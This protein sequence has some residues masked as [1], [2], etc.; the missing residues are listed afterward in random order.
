MT[1]IAPAVPHSAIVSPPP[2]ALSRPR[3]GGAHGFSAALDVLTA[4]EGNARSTDDSKNATDDP[5]DS[6]SAQPSSDLRA[7]LI[8]GAMAS[9]AI[10][11]AAV[12][13]AGAAPAH[14][15]GGGAVGEAAARKTGPAVG[16]NSAEAATAAGEAAGG[17][18]TAARA[19]VRAS[20]TAARAY[21]APAS[22]APASLVAAAP[23][24]AVV[25]F[26]ASSAAM[27][28]AFA[29]GDVGRPDPTMAE[30][31]SAAS[32]DEPRDAP[33]VVGNRAEPP[34]RTVSPDTVLSEPRLA[35][36]APGAPRRVSPTS[37]REPGSTAAA[38]GGSAGASATAGTSGPG[39]AH[40]DSDLDR[41]RQ[42]GRAPGTAAVIAA[43]TVQPNA[44]S[45][46][47]A[48]AQP[49]FSLTDSATRPA[50]AVPQTRAPAAPAAPTAPLA[51]KVRE[52]D[53]DL[54]AGGLKDVTM[55]VRLAGD[56]LGVVVRAASS[57]TA[58]TIEGAREAIAER[59]AAIGQPVTSLIIQQ[60][61]SSDAK[62]AAGQSAGE[63]EGRAP[64]EGRGEPSDPRGSRRG[65]SRF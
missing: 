40:A 35:A 3:G 45:L 49:A 44:S 4:G 12:S 57:E 5:S 42:Q 51:G 9:L 24:D 58:A 8:G 52:I 15:L 1:A 46:G 11:S 16:V 61:G 28:P 43:T 50:E 14:D 2:A 17:E 27:T 65:S 21:L 23:A 47:P 30:R 55:T 7:A 20:L 18:T 6:A 13:G 56:K 63:G 22:F 32:P 36:T 41:S 64:Q 37:S 48:P 39:K 29:P 38:T 59:L 34:D 54:S 53:L 33:V 60:T 62:G 25:T 10:V 19:T 26:D 31:N